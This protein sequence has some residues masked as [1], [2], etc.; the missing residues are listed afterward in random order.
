VD[1]ECREPYFRAPFLCPPIPAPK[2]T[3][4]SG[5]NFLP[6]FRASGSGGKSMEEKKFYLNITT[7]NEEG[8][9]EKKTVYVIGGSVPRIQAAVL[10]S[11]A[12]G[13]KSIPLQH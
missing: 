10:E 6:A 1:L 11:K 2:A 5:Q 7:L 13:K 9:K 4:L 8:K 12:A 3:G